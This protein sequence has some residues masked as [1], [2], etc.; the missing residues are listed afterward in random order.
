MIG[1]GYDRTMLKL[2]DNLDFN[3]DVLL[4][5]DYSLKQMAILDASEQ[6]WES[7]VRG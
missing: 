3:L 4:Y 7:T 1:R 2:L 6:R 5:R